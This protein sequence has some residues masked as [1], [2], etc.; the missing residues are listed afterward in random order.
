MHY[1]HRRGMWFGIRWGLR[2]YGARTAGTVP[3]E[4]ADSDTNRDDGQY[5]HDNHY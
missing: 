5:H 1:R 4:Q 2:G 3:R